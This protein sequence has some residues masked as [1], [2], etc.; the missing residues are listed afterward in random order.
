[1]RY[2]K[3]Q[4][5]TEFGDYKKTKTVYALD[6]TYKKIVSDITNE[7]NDFLEQKSTLGE[8]KIYLISF[9]TFC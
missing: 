7:L 3:G 1:M 6:N 4:L 9:K 5:V 2:V 8:K